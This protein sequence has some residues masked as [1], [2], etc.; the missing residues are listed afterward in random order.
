MKTTVCLSLWHVLSA[1]LVAS[2]L[3][4]CGTAE[5]THRVFSEDL[6]G[7]EGRPFSYATGFLNAWLKEQAPMKNAAPENGDELRTLF[8]GRTSS[9]WSSEIQAC[10]VALEVSPTQQIVKARAKG[11]GCWRPY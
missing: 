3:A 7:Y 5:G 4:G 9:R 10:T 8:Y 2:T 11:E 6:R 1:L